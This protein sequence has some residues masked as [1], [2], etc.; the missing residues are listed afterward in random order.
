MQKQF[1]LKRRSAFAYV[2]RKGEK[3]SSRNL[4]L[5]YTKS[6]GGIK[7]GISVSKKVGGAVVRNRVKRLIREA[8]NNIFPQIKEGYT[9]VIV[10]KS[11]AGESDYYA[12]CEDVK[13]IFERAEKLC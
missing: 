5:L 2:Y 3:S 10:A 13:A 8:I 12:I 4:L 9:Y 11:T 1:R 6:R 7:I